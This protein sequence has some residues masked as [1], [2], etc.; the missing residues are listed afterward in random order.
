MVRNAT[1]FFSDT[2]RM[3]EGQLGSTLELRALIDTKRSKGKKWVRMKG[4]MIPDRF[5]A[6]RS[7]M[8][9]GQSRKM[10]PTGSI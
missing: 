1:L 9:T 5:Q 8:A 10:R 3:E 2:A 7:S 4:G 6:Q